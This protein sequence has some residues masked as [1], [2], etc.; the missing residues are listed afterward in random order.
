[1][2]SATVSL[3]LQGAGLRKAFEPIQK[4]AAAPFSGASGRRVVAIMRGQVRKEFTSRSWFMPSGGRR[5]WAKTHA[6]GNKPASSTPLRATGRYF[7]SLMGGAGSI[8]R[9]TDRQITVGAVSA[10]GAVHRGGTGARIVTSPAVIRPRRKAATRSRLGRRGFARGFAMFWRLLGDFGVALSAATM[11]RG[12]RLPRRPHMTR[13]PEG[14]R[15]MARSVERYV[16]TGR[17]A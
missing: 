9:I 10:Y 2:P 1:M 12:L 15:L 14:T 3:R 7:A 4:R 8:E 5:S 16:A 6:F 17:V 11:R 13:H